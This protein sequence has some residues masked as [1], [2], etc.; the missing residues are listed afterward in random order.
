MALWTNT[1]MLRMAALAAILILTPGIAVAEVCDKGDLLPEILPE[2]A[3]WVEASPLRKQLEFLLLPGN[4][5]TAALM[6]WIVSSGR[7]QST[8]AGAAWFAL[9][10][11]LSAFGYFSIDLNEPYYQAAMRE[12][13]VENSPYRMLVN[14]AFSGAAVLLT[15]Q[16]IQRQKN[17]A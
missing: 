1:Y 3:Q 5:I 13:C 7:P 15:L 4:W 17:S 9:L 2:F 12:G 11:A 10:S 6:I 8:I 14:L 16:R